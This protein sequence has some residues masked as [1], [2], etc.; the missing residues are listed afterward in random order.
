MNMSERLSST[1]RMIVTTCF[2]VGLAILLLDPFTWGRVSGV[3]QLIAGALAVVL[4]TALVAMF[5][6]RGEMP[7]EEFRRMSER[8]ELLATLPPGQLQPSEFEEAVV[9]AIDDLPQEVQDVLKDVPIVISDLGHQFHAYGHYIG[10]TVARDDFRD[11]I[12]IYQDTLERDFGWDP[13]LLRA[14]ITRTV[15]HEVAHHLGWNEE[16]VE[17]LGL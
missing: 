9:E 5:L 8:S 7:E 15:R 2:L 10:D 4:A 6:G 11:H 3:V 17:N 12:V 13:D 16:G 14:Q 1:T